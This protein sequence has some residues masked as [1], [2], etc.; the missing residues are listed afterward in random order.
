MKH[1]SRNCSTSSL[2]L[3]LFISQDDYWGGFNTVLQKVRTITFSLR[4]YKTHVR[5]FHNYYHTNGQYVGER[6]PS[7]LQGLSWHKG[8][9]S[10]LQHR[11]VKPGNLYSS[12]ASPESSQQAS[13]LCELRLK[14]GVVFI[15]YNAGSN[16]PSP[17]KMFC[18]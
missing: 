8:R 14:R 7:W 1:T 18:V 11:I 13:V 2:F 10:H 9:N 12:I 4:M 17:Y 5:A 15:L 6:R 3:K 16:F